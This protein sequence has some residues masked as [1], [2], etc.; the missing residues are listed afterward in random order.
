MDGRMDERTDGRTNRWT[1]R[2]IHVGM[3]A[4]RR[5]KWDIVNRQI[6]DEWSKWVDNSLYSSQESGIS[7]RKPAQKSKK[8]KKEKEDEQTSE[9]E[10]ELEEVNCMSVD[11][12]NF[13]SKSVS[14]K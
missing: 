3:Q 12:E 14:R 6:M 11:M 2:Q 10:N 8:R 9:E 4:N 7:T 5:E 13:S 1:D